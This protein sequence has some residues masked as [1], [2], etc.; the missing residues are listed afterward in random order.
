MLHALIWSAS[1]GN[2]S[3]YSANKAF[4]FAAQVAAAF[5]NP[6]AEIIQHSV[7]NQE[8]G[9][10]GPAVEFFYQPDFLIAEGFAVS[11]VVS[12]LWEIRKPMWLLTRIKVG[13]SAVCRKPS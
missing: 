5:A 7:R 13:R 9:V 1:S 12:C 4:P 8:F 2:F 11:G 3:P 6:V 10:F